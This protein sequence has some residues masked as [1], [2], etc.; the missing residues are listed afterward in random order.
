[1]DTR[2]AL[3]RGV[4]LA[5]LAGASGLAGC[6]A[7]ADGGDGDTG[8]DGAPNTDA[9]G[10]D[11]SEPSGRDRPADATHD[12]VV[13]AVDDPPDLPVD[14][15]VSLADP[16]VD[17]D[18]PVVLRVDVNN[19]T[20]EA[21]VVGEYRPV[22]FQYVRDATGTLVWYPH[23]ERS[24]D[25]EPDRSLPDLGLAEEGCWRLDSPLAQTME[26][27]TVE[28]PAGGTLTAFVGLYALPDAPGGAGCFPAGE[29]R[30]E[31]HYTVMEDG[32][33]GEE[34]PSATWGFDLT[35]RAVDR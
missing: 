28:V 20:D 10:G 27:G 13:A 19:P 15:R 17:G 23:S 1:M 5:G 25:G 22:V 18:S 16:H 12:A 7:L 2:R 33:G 32:F 21:V 34:N 26:Y 6:T 31:A 4:G 8:G 30:F 9:D 14:P 29:F 35:L 24:T 11:G 3:L